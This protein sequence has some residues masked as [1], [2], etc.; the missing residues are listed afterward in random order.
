MRLVVLLGFVCRS[1]GHVGSCHGF[2]DSHPRALDARFISLLSL[3]DEVVLVSQV[4]ISRDLHNTA[5]P[6][7][8]ALHCISRVIRSQ[9]RRYLSRVT[10]L[11]LYIRELP[12]APHE[13]SG[14]SQYYR[15][16]HVQ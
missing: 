1:D 12:L 6:V 13:Q 8:F 14:C 5:G 7:L 4:V 3:A 2:F 11:A 10:L 9:W 16:I 15:N